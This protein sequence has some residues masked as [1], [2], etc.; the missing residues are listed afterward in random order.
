MIDKNKCHW[1]NRRTG[2]RAACDILTCLQCELTG[3][4]SFYE[5]DEQ[6][7][8]RQAR[9]TERRKSAIRDWFEKRY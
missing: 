8:E 9:F 5:T 3:K 6:Y 7:N 4:C 2:C 1:F